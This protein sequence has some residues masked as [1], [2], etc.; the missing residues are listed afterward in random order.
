MRRATKWKLGWGWSGLVFP[1]LAWAQP[2]P[3]EALLQASYNFEN[4]V[5]PWLGMGETAKLSL[6]RGA[7]AV[8]EGDGALRFDY[9]VSIGQTNLLILPTA[10][11]GLEN[12]K[13]VAFWVKADYSTTL[14]AIFIEQGGGRFAAMVH[15]PAKQWQRVELS[16]TDFLLLSGPTDP[17]DA[18]GELD[19]GQVEAFSLADLGQIFAGTID[20][21]LATLLGVQT[22][23][24]FFL[25]DGF[26]FGQ[27]ALPMAEPLT[28]T[29]GEK[30]V[31]I[32]PLTHPQLAWNS[33]GGAKLGIETV[34]GLPGRSLQAKYSQERD[35]ISGLMRRVKPGLLQGTTRLRLEATSDKT[36]TFIARFEEKGGGKYNASLRL[37]GGNLV[38]TIDVNFADFKPAEDSKDKNQRL[39]LD[40]IEQIG[41]LDI[42]GALGAP[43]G[44]NTFNINNL[45]ATK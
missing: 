37:V 40:Q 29:D 42:S 18:N 21:K 39:D 44:E 28:K 22:G 1:A 36:A 2:L 31:A 43:G 12:T 32:E 3:P 4:A 27:Q 35:A 20:P 8:K 7:E 19:L 5:E 9:G 17:V 11:H 33:L 23:P 16:P 10:L 30:T 26:A 13:S 45:R 25:V 34:P 41:F 14:M 6:S 15:T 38:N 24:H